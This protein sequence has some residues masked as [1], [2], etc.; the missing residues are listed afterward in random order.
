MTTLIEKIQQ[1]AQKFIEQEKISTADLIQFLSSIDVTEEDIAINKRSDPAHPYGRNVLFNH[2]KLEV[3]LATWTVNFPSAPHDHGGSKSAIR[4]LKGRSHH[5]L[6]Q[7]KDEQLIEVF[8]ERKCKD[9]ILTCPPKQVH[10]M[11]DDGMEQS[12]ITL[13]A[14]SQSIPNMMVYDP[15]DSLMV[16]GKCGAWVPEDQEDILLQKKGHFLRADLS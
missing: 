15:T 5:R 8:S 6:F 11:G 3:M 2:P 14:Y 10:A 16:K 7:I 9:D 13:H 4:V 12:L 1:Q